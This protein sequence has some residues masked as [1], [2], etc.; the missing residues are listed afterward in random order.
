M[1]TSLPK[2]T[3]YIDQWSPLWTKGFWNVEISTKA[4]ERQ[5]LDIFLL[6]QPAKK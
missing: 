3:V 2:N 6:I 1:T 5:Y 4:L